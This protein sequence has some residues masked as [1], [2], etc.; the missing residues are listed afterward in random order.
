M[1]DDHYAELRAAVERLPKETTLLTYESPLG[2]GLF[3]G[4]PKTHMELTL[5]V[6]SAARRL[7]EAREK[8]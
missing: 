5:A 8:K 4:L 7:V 3:A 1:N 6:V 2:S